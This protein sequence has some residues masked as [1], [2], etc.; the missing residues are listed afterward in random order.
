L[1]KPRRKSLAERKYAAFSLLNNNK[2]MN[3]NFEKILRISTWLNSELSP[4]SKRNFMLEK[5]TV[6]L[7]ASPGT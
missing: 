5:F 2:S 3:Q 7:E 1:K 4:T 6:G